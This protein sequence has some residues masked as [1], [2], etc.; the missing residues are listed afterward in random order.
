MLKQRLITA[1]ILVP[2]FLWSVLSLSTN[3]V[4]IL[5]IL[6]IAMGAWEW[7]ALTG[8]KSFALRAGYLAAV[9]AIMLA[10]YPFMGSHLLIYSILSIAVVWWITSL[11]WINQAESQSELS[12]TSGGGDPDWKMLLLGIVVLV[13]TWTAL[14]LLHKN[15]TAGIYLMLSLFA[16]VWGADTG[17]YFAGRRWGRRK[18]APKISP[19]KT[20]EGVTGGLVVVVITMAIIASIMGYGWSNLLSFVLLGIVTAMFSIIG[21]LLESLLKRRRGVKDSGRILPGHG[22]VLD[23]ID[24][25]TAAAPVFTL[26]LMLQGVSL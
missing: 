10:I 14:I 13:P 3:T 12:R 20:W 21:D 1:A 15:G 22:G 25:L 8:L 11:I 16:I 5:F 23:R 4:A 26:G 24:S 7:S 2:L 19:G 9:V 6:V 17:A 18:L